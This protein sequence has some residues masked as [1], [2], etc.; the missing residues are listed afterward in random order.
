[1]RQFGWLRRGIR[2]DHG[3]VGTSDGAKVRATL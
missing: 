3:R 2:V 1:M